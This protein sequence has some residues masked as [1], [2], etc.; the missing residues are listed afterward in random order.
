MSQEQSATAPTTQA[1]E[2][3]KD[4]HSVPLWMLSPGEEKTLL[5]EHQ[6]WTETQCQKQFSGEFLYKYECY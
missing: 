1:S 2:N 3:S 6:A 5:K 4:N